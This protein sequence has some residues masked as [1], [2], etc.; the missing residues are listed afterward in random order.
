MLRLF[1][2][3]FLGSGEESVMGISVEDVFEVGNEIGLGLNQFG[4]S[5]FLFLALFPEFL[6]GLGDQEGGGKAGDGGG[7]YV[8]GFRRV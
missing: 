8:I 1:G 3:V 7:E 5:A 4:S 6:G 2:E